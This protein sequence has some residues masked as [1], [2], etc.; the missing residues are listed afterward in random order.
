MVQLQEEDLVFPTQ[1]H[2]LHLTELRDQARTCRGKSVISYV[3]GHNLTC[4]ERQ[5]TR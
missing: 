5:R 1:A 2:L 3:T 4:H